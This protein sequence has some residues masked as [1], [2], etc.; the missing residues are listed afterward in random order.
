MALT[1]TVAGALRPGKQLTWIG[2]DGA[3]VDLTSATLSGQMYRRMTSDQRAI[4]GTLLIIDAL[5]GVF[6][7]DYD[8]ADVVAGTYNIEFRADYPG[9]PTP[10]KTFQA[11]WQVH[12]SL[13]A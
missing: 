10:G 3:V 13:S 4:V 6:R 1:P 7:W 2:E 5:N 8:P 12:G 11:R 9:D